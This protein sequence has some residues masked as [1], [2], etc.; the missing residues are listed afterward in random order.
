MAGTRNLP[1]DANNE[2][3][4]L[5][6]QI[7]AYQAQLYHSTDNMKIN[8]LTVV[9]SLV[10]LQNA[11]AFA[12]PPLG[13]NVVARSSTTTALAMGNPIDGENIIPNV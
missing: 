5:G 3:S 13:Q 6:L 9:S 4:I 11:T 7:T 10:V 12:V 1:A 2:E 8:T